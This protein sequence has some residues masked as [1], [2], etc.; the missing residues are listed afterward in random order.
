MILVALFV[1]LTT[2]VTLTGEYINLQW[3]QGGP[4][5]FAL[6]VEGVSV[7]K[8][9][10]NIVAVVASNSYG[11]TNVQAVIMDFNY[12]KYMPTNIARTFP[13]LQYLIVRNSHVKYVTNADFSGLRSLI[14]VDFRNNDIEH[15]PGN[16]FQ[17]V[18]NV[19]A[20]VSFANNKLT[21]IASSFIPSVI[22]TL[23]GLKALNLLSNPCIN[24]NN[25]P[26]TLAT[27]ATTIQ[28]NCQALIVPDVPTGPPPTYEEYN[29]LN[30]RNI[31][32]MK[33]IENLTAELKLRND[34]I[35]ELETSLETTNTASMKCFEDKT[36]LTLDLAAAND[37]IQK[38]N[39]ILETN[40]L[41]N[42]M[43]S[44]KII[45]LSNSLTTTQGDLEKCKLASTKLQT[46]L[47]DAQNNLQT[48][49]LT[50][51]MNKQTI[52]ELNKS[53]ETLKS[54]LM[55]KDAELATSNMKLVD[56]QNALAA[57]EI[58]NKQQLA[59]IEEQKKRIADIEKVLSTSQSKLGS[60]QTAF[61]ILFNQ[62]YI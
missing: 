62:L 41:N 5:K 43:Q 42:K 46:D 58:L 45:E 48:M 47:T 21:N 51:D 6:Q 30:V 35:K 22:A 38:K 20:F 9:N 19:L 8:P 60:V 50:N 26:T 16:L 13:G 12:M 61:N 4:T 52:D 36:K 10:D 25:P 54:D 59:T 27:M 7:Y 24:L 23:P 3:Y 44:D 55:K 2:S 32:L 15:L 57:K 14:Q 33:T 40:I 28:A 39:V 1:T 56:A 53:I 49:K 17:G 31:G 18:S 34:R 29:A 11:A 37:D